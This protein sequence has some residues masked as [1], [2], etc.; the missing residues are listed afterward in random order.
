[1]SGIYWEPRFV[2]KGFKIQ[3]E[4]KV[5]QVLAGGGP[6]QPVIEETTGEPDGSPVYICM[7]PYAVGDVDAPA[8]VPGKDYYDFEDAP[9][10][11]KDEEQ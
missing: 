1:M 9:T 3:W 5:K 4:Q 8:E 7:T 2:G 6:L 11:V 10:V